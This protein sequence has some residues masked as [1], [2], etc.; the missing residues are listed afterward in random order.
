MLRFLEFHIEIGHKTTERLGKSDF[1]SCITVPSNIACKYMKKIAHAVL[2]TDCI[3]CVFR[4]CFYIFERPGRGSESPK[5][6]YMRKVIVLLC[7]V[8]SKSKTYV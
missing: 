8:T 3:F 4:F 5:H 1:L 6:L 7:L 2:L